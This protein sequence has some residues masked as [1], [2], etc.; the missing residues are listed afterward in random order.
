MREIKFR[1]WDTK[2]EVMIDASAKDSFYFEEYWGDMRGIE[3]TVNLPD[4]YIVE[5]YTGLL[6]KNGVE[7]FE[8]DIVR[9]GENRI[10]DMDEQLAVKWNDECARFMVTNGIGYGFWI[11]GDIGVEVIGNIHEGTI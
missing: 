7:I 2:S 1:A 10:G 4:R 8:G 5:Q 11:S 6:D 3:L 9:E